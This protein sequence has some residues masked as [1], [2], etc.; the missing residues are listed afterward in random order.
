MAN[1]RLTG[2]YSRFLLYPCGRHGRWLNVLFL[3]CAN[4]DNEFES[5]KNKI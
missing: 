4:L 1:F 2:S 3:R 5:K